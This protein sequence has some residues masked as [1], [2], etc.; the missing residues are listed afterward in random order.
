VHE[1]QLSPEL[2]KLIDAAKTAAEQAGSCGCRAEGAAVLTES[3]QIFVGR[4]GRGAEVG[5]TC[6]V[7]RAFA[8]AG[9]PG[10]DGV[11]AIALAAANDRATSFIPCEVCG[12]FLGSLD[13]ELPVVTKQ[14][15]R[16]VMQPLS[17]L[18]RA[19]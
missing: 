19:V 5:P 12:S 1:E 3:A 18:V 9:L 15:G 4:S 7:A 11:V 13:P 6:S 10:G 17:E 16:W 2:G 14:L 8:A